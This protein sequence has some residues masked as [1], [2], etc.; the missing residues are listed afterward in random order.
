[1]KTILVYGG[2]GSGKSVVC[3]LLNRRGIPSYDADSRTKQLYEENSELRSLIVSAFGTDVLE[4]TAIDRRKLAAMAFADAGKLAQLE[5]IVHPF[6]K[7]DF[8]QWR[9]AL[10]CTCCIIE[11]AIAQSKPLFADLFDFRVLVDAPVELR[12]ER[13]CKRDN[14]SRE[15]ILQRI[16]NQDPNSCRPDFVINN[17]GNLRQL[18][19][20]LDH[21]LAKGLC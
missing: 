17:D 21:L 1:V 16:G 6:V 12:I 10:T 11:S 19:Q 2:I 13:A 14:S 5:G 15:L 4:G 20:Q 8:L 7:A 9:D 3:S 18:E